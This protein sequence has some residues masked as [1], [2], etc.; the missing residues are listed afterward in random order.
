MPIHARGRGPAGNGLTG[1]RLAD[2]RRQIRLAIRLGEQQ[3]SGVEPAVMDDRIFGVAR[4]KQHLEPG[5]GFR[6]LVGELAAVHRAG[7]DHVGEQQ[8]KILAGFDDGE[9]F[10]GIG[11]IQRDVAQ[12]MQLRQDVIPHQL[13]VLDDQDG[14]MPALDGRRD[15][16]FGRGQR[17]GARRQIHLDGGA[18]A[19]LAVDHDVSGG[20]LHETVD[21][22]EAET[23]TFAGPL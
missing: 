16:V 11:R 17:S 3:D 5:P 12:R 22:A 9:R 6:R 8:I 13:V 20:L 10:R 19:L 2:H 18:V 21:H 1:E 4:G 7:H 23:G 15:C 14:F